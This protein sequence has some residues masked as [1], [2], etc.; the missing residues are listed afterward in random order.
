MK[1]KQNRTGRSWRKKALTGILAVSMI[2]QT[3]GI[4]L[5]AEESAGIT[6]EAVLSESEDTGSESVI[7]TAG[8][9]ESEGAAAPA[10]NEETVK[11]DS[12]DQDVG[13]EAPAE[14]TEIP[15]NPG[16]VTEPVEPENPEEVTDPEV[17][18]EP[19]G[20]ETLE[21]PSDPEIPEDVTENQE[22][23]VLEDAG[24][25][26]VTIIPK[27]E[28]VIFAGT[29]YDLLD[30]VIADPSVLTVNGKEV[31]VKIGISS[32]KRQKVSTDGVSYVDDPSYD[33]ETLGRPT[34][35]TPESPQQ[36]YV[37]TYRAY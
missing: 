24:Q 3:S 33:W 6:K 4:T 10:E 8:I 30:G 26:D 23:D 7:P 9:T 27:L 32:L 15:E 13:A 12:S 21:E 1:R 2:F 31:S 28:G 11:E 19:S 34:S 36:Q 25:V 18:A 5:F 37:V 35:I 17:P 16:E 20:D 14:V 22:T 29:D